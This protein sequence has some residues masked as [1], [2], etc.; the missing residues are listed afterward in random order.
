[1][2]RIYPPIQPED[3]YANLIETDALQT[4]ALER[5]VLVATSSVYVEFN[6]ETTFIT[7]HAVSKDIYLK[8]A[9]DDQDYCNATNF[10][11]MIE[12]GTHRVFAIPTQYTGVPYTG[13]QCVS[14]ESG[15]TVIVIEK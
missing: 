3:K 10:D 15:G 11:E 5:N 7:V 8:W 14:R 12:S 6:S 13:I 4:T 1:M 9:D 2:T